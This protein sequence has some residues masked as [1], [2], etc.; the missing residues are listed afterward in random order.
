MIRAENKTKGVTFKVWNYKHLV[1]WRETMRK[2]YF[3]HGGKKPTHEFLN[4]KCQNYVHFIYFCFFICYF[5]WSEI[6]LEFLEDVGPLL[7]TAGKIVENDVEKAEASCV[8]CDSVI[9]GKYSVP[10]YPFEINNEKG[11]NRI[12][13][14][15]KKFKSQNWV[16]NC[17]VDNIPHSLWGQTGRKDWRDV[18]WYEWKAAWSIRLKPSLKG[19]D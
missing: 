17:L 2:L 19:G 6:Q 15:I 7:N 3:A 1:F 13:S 9:M 4:L 10:K 11:N 14:R 8:F 18:P 16:N 5:S 12:T